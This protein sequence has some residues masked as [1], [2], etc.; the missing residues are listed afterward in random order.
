MI[1][2]GFRGAIV[3]AMS[4]LACHGASAVEGVGGKDATGK[5][6]LVFRSGAI[7]TVNR[8]QPWAEAVAIKGNEIVFVGS[9]KEVI[10]FVGKQTRVVDLAGKMVMP[11]IHDVHIHPMESGSDNTHFTLETDEQDAERFIDVIARANEENPGRGWLVGYGHSLSSL[12]DARRLPLAII[13]DAVADRPVIIMEQTSHS[14]WVNSTAL[15]LAGIDR[16]TADPVGGVIGREEESDELNGILYDN[17]GEMVMALAMQPTAERRRRDYRGMVDYV[18]P[19]LA[20]HGITSISDARTYWQRDQHK[21]WLELQANDEL[22]LRVSLGLWAYPELDDKTQLAALK[23]L[24]R[25]EPDSLLRINQVKLYLDGILANTTAAMHEPYLV[26]KLGLPGNRGLNYFDQQRLQRYIA[27]LEPVGF[28]FHMHAIGDRGIHQ[29]L[30]A[31]EKAAGRQGRHRITHLETV[32]PADLRRFARLNVTAD[33]QVAG[34]FSQPGHWQ[35]NA[36]LIGPE[37]A[38]HAVPIRSLHKAGARLTLSSDW[39]VSPFNPFIGLQNAVTRAPEHLS[40]ED[41]IVAYTLNGA[42]TMRQEGR[43]GS[44][45]TGKLADLIVLDRN[46]FEIP[47]TSIAKTRVVMTLVDGDVVYSRK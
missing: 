37:R 28:D 20:E 41:A 32:D 26:D 15:A 2:A 3:L 47:K 11:G 18:M 27:D 39:S 23:A 30:N 40:L 34:E 46:L 45:E 16:Q 12:T 33:A 4:V 5:A 36:P 31:V 22:T 29:A 42:Y 24:Y 35:E 1:K 43:V 7:Y 44:I 14:M 38:D 10:S 13:D 19:A 25:D 8:Q 17:A 9:D 21:T 6:S